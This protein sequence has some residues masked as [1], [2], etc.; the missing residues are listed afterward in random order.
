MDT[1]NIVVRILVEILPLVL[2]ITLH[3]AAHGYVARMFGDNTAYMMGRVTLNP[4]RHI[5]PV[6]TILFPLL[7]LAL[8]GVVFGWAKPVPVNFGNLR[9]PK[10]DMFWV[11]AAGPGSNLVQATIWSAVAATI[12]SYGGLESQA[13]AFWF[14]VAMAGIKWNVILAIFNL[15][16][17]LPLDGGRIVTSLLPNPLAYSYS[18]LEPYGMPILIGLII[19]MTVVPPLGYAFMALI[20]GGINV[21]VTLFGLR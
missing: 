3:E 9:H 14:L 15:F 20:N 12:A 1:G 2:A 5:D 13:A 19:L 21:F 10:R 4:A 8:G 16:P 18:R 17:I 7:S 6:G 11:A